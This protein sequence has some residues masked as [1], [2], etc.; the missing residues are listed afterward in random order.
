MVLLYTVAG[1]FLLCLGSAED[2]Y[3]EHPSHEGHSRFEYPNPMS[4]TGHVTC[5][6][7]EKSYIC[8]PDGI[9]LVLEGYRNP[10]VVI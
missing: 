4:V 7:T 8:D 3:Q 2:V 10:F 5:H 1:C 9:I 6:R